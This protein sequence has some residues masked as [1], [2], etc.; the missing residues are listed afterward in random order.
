MLSP[1]TLPKTLTLHTYAVL[2]KILSKK[3]VSFT[4]KFNKKCYLHYIGLKQ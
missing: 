3:Y 2:F 1:L 4:S